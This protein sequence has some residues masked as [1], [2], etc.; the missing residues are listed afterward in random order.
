MEKSLQPCRHKKTKRK[1]WVNT[2]WY[3][4]TYI[5]P[6]RETLLTKYIVDTVR[7]GRRA[8][9]GKGTV[10]FPSSVKKKSEKNFGY[11]AILEIIL[12]FQTKNIFISGMK[13]FGKRI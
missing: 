4:E 5:K 1:D 7:Y 11:Y 12:Y 3:E 2:S 6:T 10:D 9:T 13:L 8:I